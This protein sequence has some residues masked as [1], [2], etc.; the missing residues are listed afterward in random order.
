LSIYV[1]CTTEYGLFVF[2]PV[3]PKSVLDG[4]LAGCHQLL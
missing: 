2:L 1:M 3:R 4:L